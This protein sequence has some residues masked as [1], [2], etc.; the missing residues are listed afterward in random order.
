M[1]TPLVLK[2]EKKKDSSRQFQDSLR[3]MT[4]RNNMQSFLNADID[5]AEPYSAAEATKFKQQQ[6]LVGNMLLELIKLAEPTSDLRVTVRSIE[7]SAAFS[8]PVKKMRKNNSSLRR[9]D[10]AKSREKQLF[11]I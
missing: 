1:T 4:A 11:E 2:G 9:S 6:Q 5:A 3:E 8:T 7:T 10:S